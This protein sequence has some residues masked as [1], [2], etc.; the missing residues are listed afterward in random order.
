ML[1]TSVSAHSLKI[2]LSVTRIR[3]IPRGL[4]PS[5]LPAERR[6]GPAPVNSAHLQ[7]FEACS[8]GIPPAGHVPTVGSPQIFRGSVK[9][10]P[11]ATA[12]ASGWQVQYE[13]WLEAK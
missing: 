3:Q 1:P 8:G 13:L 6:Q 11:W 10:W 7:Y 9:K 12:D 5:P 4:S 2:K